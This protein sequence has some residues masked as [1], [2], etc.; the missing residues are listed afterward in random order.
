[1]T[2]FFGY[3]CDIINNNNN[4]N[5]IKTIRNISC[6]FVYPVIVYIQ[7]PTQSASWKQRQK[8]SLPTP[9]YGWSQM[10]N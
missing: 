6:S 1:M 8:A 2:Q 7:N 9:E 10:T 3:I 5:S 4:K